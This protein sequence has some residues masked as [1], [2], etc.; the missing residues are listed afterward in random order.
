LDDHESLPTVEAQEFEKDDDTNFH[1]DFLHALTNLR[2]RNY[3]LDEMDWLQV[4]PVERIV[5]PVC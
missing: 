5:F 2:A 3:K 4:C 1:I